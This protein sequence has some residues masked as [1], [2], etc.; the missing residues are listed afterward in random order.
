[1]S[2][3]YLFS[4]LGFYPLDP[5]SATYVLGAPFF[6]RI[7]L[8]LPRA[9]T[10]G[11]SDAITVV[12]KGASQGRKYVRG[13]KVN[14]KAQGLVIAHADIKDGASVEFEMADTPQAWPKK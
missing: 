6:D 12:A 14:G 10:P 13:V 2:A 8:R 1:M 3:W 9:F 7:E 5:A 4:A 11:L